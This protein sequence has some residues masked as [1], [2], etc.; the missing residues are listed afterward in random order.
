[1]LFPGEMELEIEVTDQESIDQFG[2]SEAIFNGLFPSGFIFQIEEMVEHP[3]K[4]AIVVF[5]SFEHLC[6]MFSHAI[7]AQLA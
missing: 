1:M 2:V 6:K 4:T 3:E 7:E 5:F